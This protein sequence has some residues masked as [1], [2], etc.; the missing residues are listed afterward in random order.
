MF[1]RWAERWIGYD[2][3]LIAYEK[4]K[5]DN[6]NITNANESLRKRHKNLRDTYARTLANVQAQRAELAKL[7]RLYTRTLVELR[8]EQFLNEQNNSESDDCV[9][10]RLMDHDQAWDVADILGERFGKPMYAHSC[11]V[12]PVNPITRDRWWHVTRKKT[13]RRV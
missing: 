1:R 2:R 5:R 11:A 12:C 9:K 6:H 10:I 3:L 7:H 4:L 13:R 8:W